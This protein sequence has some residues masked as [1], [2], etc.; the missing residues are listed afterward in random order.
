MPLV[1][2]GASSE[3]KKSARSVA[4]T[5]LSNSV[6]RT[7]SRVRAPREAGSWAPAQLPGGGCAPTPPPPPPFLPPSPFLLTLNDY[8]CSFHQ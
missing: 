7:G 1:W 4:S 5:G 2:E 8:D 6:R 3:E